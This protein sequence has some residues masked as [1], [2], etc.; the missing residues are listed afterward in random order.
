MYPI[1]EV[2]NGS[3]IKTYSW[4]GSKLRGIVS[5]KTYI[6]DYNARGIRER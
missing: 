3:I 5:D 2:E 4:L 6:F 1:N